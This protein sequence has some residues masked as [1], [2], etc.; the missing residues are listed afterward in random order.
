MNYNNP[1]IKTLETL[2]NMAIVSFLWLVFSLPVLTIVPSSAALF[3]TTSKIIFGSGKGNGVFKDF[4]D[5]FKENLKEGAILS[6]IMI[7]AALFIAEGL[8]TGFQFHKVSLWGMAYFVLGIVIAFF[9]VTALVHIAPVLSRFEAPVS[10][11]IRMA[12]YFAIRKPLRSILFCI[13][14]VAMVLCVYAFPLALLMVPAVYAD[15]QRGPLDKDFDL[16]AEE[17]GLLEEETEETEEN[18]EKKQEDASIVDLEERFSK[19]RK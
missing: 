10:S 14:F 2:A 18:I 15:F 11:I 5:S 4:F 6:L 13:L 7:I 3:H 19:E 17:N 9:F 1:F 12:V 8:W 16:F